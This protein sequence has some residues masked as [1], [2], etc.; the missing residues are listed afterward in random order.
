MSEETLTR[1]DLRRESIIAVAREVFLEEGFAAAS[2][3]AIAARLGGSKGTLYNYFPCKEAL[4]EAFVRD[5]CGR[6]TDSVLDALDDAPVAEVLTDLGERFLDNLFSDWALATFRIIVAEAKRNPHLARIFYE[7]GPAV[8]VERLRAYLERARAAG[9]IDA[10][11]C[12]EAAWQFLALCRGH[13]HLVLTLN[14]AERPSKAA[15][16]KT[17]AESV[18]MFMARYGTGS[19]G[20]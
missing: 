4:F 2:M 6:F 7:A 19:K 3:S 11:D 8:S 15:I 20:R 5:Q 17:V 9:Q 12:R 16:A 18:A 14:L 10:E 13:D 1:K